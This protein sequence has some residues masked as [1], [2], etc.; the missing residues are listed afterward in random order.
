[1]FLDQVWRDCRL[2]IRNREKEQEREKKELTY[3]NI[4]SNREMNRG[5]RKK[6]HHERNDTSQIPRPILLFCL[7]SSLIV[8][9]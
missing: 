6:I 3:A 1:M 7:L 8:I 2:E 9:Q 5:T 4:Y